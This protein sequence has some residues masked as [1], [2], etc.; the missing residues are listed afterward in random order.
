M[1]KELERGVYK[2]KY[3]NI[4]LIKKLK[5]NSITDQT[6]NVIIMFEHLF[7]LSQKPI[8][9]FIPIVIYS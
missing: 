3:N 2:Y 5:E 7:C 9:L 1:G 4:K 8:E 6:E